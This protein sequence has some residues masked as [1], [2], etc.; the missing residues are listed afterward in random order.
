MASCVAEQA[1][2]M[3]QLVAVH[4]LDATHIADASRYISLLLLSLRAMLTL[5]LPHVNV[6]SK[7][8]LLGDVGADIASDEQDRDDSGSVEMD[9]DRPLDQTHKAVGQAGLG[10]FSIESQ[11][12]SDE[13]GSL[14]SGLL[15]RSARS[16]LSS[17]SSQRYYGPSSLPS[18]CTIESEDM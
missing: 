12:K 6:L 1:L 13:I 7:V 10:E 8:D 15:H 9:E 2:S 4:L 3:I 11:D 17:G 14:Q 18:I 16:L 5:E